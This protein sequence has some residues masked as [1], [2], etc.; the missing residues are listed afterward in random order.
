MKYY[1]RNNLHTN[2]NYITRTLCLA[3]ILL[4]GLLAGCNSS[5]NSSSDDSSLVPTV[6]ATTPAESDTDVAINHKAVATFSEAMDSTTIDT[7]SFSVIGADE[8]ALSGDVTVDTASH[9]ATFTPDGNFAASTLYTATLTTAIK[10]TAESVALANDYVWSFTS[11]TATDVVAPTVI[12]T[13]PADAATG[14]ALNRA[15]SANVSEA[16]DPATVNASTFTLTPAVS[17]VVSYSDKVATFSPSSNLAENTSYTATLT[18]AITDLG[19]VALTAKTWSFTTGT[20]VAEGPAPVNLG[21]AGDFAILTKTGVTNVHASAITGNVGASPITAAAMDNVNCIEMTGIIYG[22]DVG[23]TG[24]GD[25]SC[26]KGTAPDNTLVANAVLDM[27]TAYTDAAGRKTPYKTDLGAGKIGGLTLT[28]GLYKWGTSVLI[29]TDV[30]LS[31]GANDVWIF[32]I[33]G[34]LTQETATHVYLD[35]DAQA[36]NVFWQVGGVDGVTLN[37]DAAFNGIVMAEKT[38][39]VRTGATVNGRLLSQTEVTLQQ[40]TVTQPAQ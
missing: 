30:T 39:A 9:T 36:K 24:N 18:T 7:L 16:L 23:Y 1:W 20:T 6:I 37:T 34:N 31:G 17:G 2:T 33:A 5:S 19:D 10:S 3:S 11:G 12:S 29:D 32:Q 25:I 22:S 13:N 26:F 21:I 38:I 27:G 40:N 4:T 35:G 8:Q 15:I 28:P 14:F